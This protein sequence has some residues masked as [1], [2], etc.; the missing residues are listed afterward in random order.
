M[1]EHS[2]VV[3]RVGV[4]RL[5]FE[6]AGGVPK[7]FV[8]A[9]ESAHRNREVVVRLRVALPNDKCAIQVVDGPLILAARAERHGKV[10]VNVGGVG[11]YGEL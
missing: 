7:I 3:P 5:Q 9:A 4:I 8:E 10:V 2:Q 6:R 11:V 1:A